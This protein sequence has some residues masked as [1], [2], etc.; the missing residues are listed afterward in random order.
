[1]RQEAIRLSI[2]QRRQKVLWMMKAIKVTCALFASVL[3][4]GAVGATSASAVQGPFW[5]SA[6]DLCRAFVGNG[7]KEGWL[8]AGGC[9]NLGAGKEKIA[10]LVEGYEVVESRGVLKLESGEEAPVIDENVG[11]FGFATSIFTIT[12]EHVTS[13][14][15][16]IG[17]NPGTDRA[18]VTFSSC[19]VNGHPQCDVWSQGQPFGQVFV[20][21]KSELVY[22]ENAENEKVGDLFTPKTGTRFVSLRATALS[23]G[24]CPVGVPSSGEEEGGI[25]YGTS[26]IKGSIVAKVEPVNE[27]ELAGALLF[28]EAK[29]A[30]AFQ[31]VGGTLKEVKPKLTYFELAEANESGTE[32]V[33]LA[34]DES[35][36]VQVP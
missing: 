17:G 2:R 22:L 4:L 8:L 20:E 14:G 25:K 3:A 5:L 9:T 27:H 26:N 13:S 7:V 35:W 12:C 30:K 6:K 33:S 29:I 15:T 1:M 19:T 32:Q 28:P 16:L 24:A 34:N 18:N 31:N 23:E 36:G 21:L 10:N 11:N